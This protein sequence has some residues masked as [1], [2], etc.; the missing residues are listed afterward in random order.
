MSLRHPVSCCAPSSEWAIQNDYKADFS[1]QI[2]TKSSSALYP[3]CH[4]VP[5]RARVAHLALLY[6]LCT[7]VLI[8][9]LT[10][11]LSD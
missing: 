4:V 9:H 1:R 10:N 6:Y 3:R 2:A 11:L 7:I 5:A 8:Y